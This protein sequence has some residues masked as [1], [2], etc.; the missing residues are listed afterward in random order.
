MSVAEAERAVEEVAALSPTLRVS[1]RVLPGGRI[2]LASPYLHEGEVVEV[3]IRLP[4]DPAPAAASPP[5]EQAAAPDPAPA[6]V[7]P[8]IAWLRS[9]PPGPRSADTWEEV[10]RIFQQE[11]DSWDR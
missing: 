7:P 11:R 3:N 4:A 2:D 8:L 6:E 5:A 10:E 1:T 9:L